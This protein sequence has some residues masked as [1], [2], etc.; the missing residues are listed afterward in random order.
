ML[1]CVFSLHLGTIDLTNAVSVTVLQ[2]IA[3]FV[4]LHFWSTVALFSL[5]CFCSC[6][7][8]VSS[9]MPLTHPGSFQILLV[10]ETPGSPP[11]FVLLFLSLELALVSRVTEL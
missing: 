11:E 9:F 5:A 1:G 3:S 7:S 6:G 2:N 4:L 10:A 8:F